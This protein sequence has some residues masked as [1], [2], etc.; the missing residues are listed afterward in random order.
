[1]TAPSLTAQAIAHALLA[2]PWDRHAM[3][4]R[5]RLVLGDEP[6]WLGDWVSRILKRHPAPPAHDALIELLLRSTRFRDALRG[7]PP[8][9]PVRRWLFAEPRM[10]P[11]AG[12]P[13]SW[14]VP[15]LATT[16]DVAS[17]FD[18]SV[19]DLLW[20]ADPDGWEQRRRAEPLRHY[21]YRWLTKP[22]GGYRIVEAPKPR[23]KA[24]QRKVLHNLLDRVPAHEAA[25]A[26]RRGSSAMGH[27]ERH[28][29]RHVLLR[30]DLRDFFPS[31]RARR[32]RALLRTLGYP[33]EVA[34]LLTGLTTNQVPPE[35]W[36]HAPGVVAFTDV[37][38]RSAAQRF[39][40]MPH[41]PAGAPTSPALANLVAWRL[42]MRLSAAASASGFTYSRYADDLTFSADEPVAS[43]VH[44]FL[45]L[46]K[47]IVDDEGFVVNAR[48][49]RIMGRGARQ[50]V[51]GLVVNDRLNVAR[52]DVDRLRA[53]LH[54]A[55]R[56]SL[57]AQN[58]S[59]HPDFRAHL[60]GRIAWVE[61]VHPA[62]GR[63]LRAEL[64]RLGH[65]NGALGRPHDR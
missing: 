10:Q 1:M 54:N 65:G 64:A 50:T 47:T 8:P 62:R 52:G 5:V 28:V 25:C 56:T 14:T 16:G 31:I 45:A 37:Q 35:A 39:Y 20:F 59:G 18:L 12:A 51:A 41:L 46:V 57:E 53:I 24:L 42:D 34:R 11:A 38:A 29:G 23:L 61:S 21:Q 3:R 44:P 58:R 9:L 33:D 43:A 27:A 15:S 49:T 6:S 22:S 32:V 4:D 19:A 48:K 17:W 36:A 26:F 7:A 63:E 30:V 13:A 40:R 60:Q 55:A 2:G